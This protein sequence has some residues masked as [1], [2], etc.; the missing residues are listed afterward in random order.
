MTRLV[1]GDLVQVRSDGSRRLAFAHRLGTPLVDDHDVI[2]VPQ[3]ARLLVV[4][5]PVA[6]DDTEPNIVVLD[7]DGT[8]LECTQRGLLKVWP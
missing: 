6:G 4:A 5:V 8:L 2:R 7:E 3:R 1:P